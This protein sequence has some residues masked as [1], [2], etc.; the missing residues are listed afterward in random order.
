MEDI[1]QFLTGIFYMRYYEINFFS[2][3]LRLNRCANACIISVERAK[4]WLYRVSFYA[5][6]WMLHHG[7]ALKFDFR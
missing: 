2:K 1:T 4:N 3:L 5:D 7:T 6:E